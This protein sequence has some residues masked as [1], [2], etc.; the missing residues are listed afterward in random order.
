MNILINTYKDKRNLNNAPC[1]CRNQFVEVT[2]LRFG[3]TIIELPRKCYS[4]SSESLSPHHFHSIMHVLQ[5]ALSPPLLA[6]SL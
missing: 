1:F 5:E 6:K 2:L 4:S 3:V